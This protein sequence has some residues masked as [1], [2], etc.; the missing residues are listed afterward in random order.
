MSETTSD[1]KTEEPTPR[2]LEKAIE[3]GQIAF[4]SE[5]MGG[6]VVLAGVLFFLFLGRWFFDTI[7]NSIRE[8]LFYFQPMIDD[9]ISVL[10]A[11]RHSLTQFGMACGALMVFNFVVAAAAGAFQTKFNLSMKPISFDLSKLSP[12]KGLK[13]IFSSRSL[14]RGLVAISKATAIVLAAIYLTKAKLG[15]I[16][17]A[18]LLSLPDAIAVG[19]ELVLKMGLVSATLMVL[20]G[21][22]DYAFQKWKQYTDLKMSKQEVRDE[23]KD[24]DGD[25]L[26]KARL[27]RVQN[28]RAKNRMLQEVPTATV[29]ITNPTHFAVAVKYSA[30]ENSAPIVV[31]KGQDLLAFRIIEIAKEN[32]VAVVERKPVARFLYANV[33]VGQPIPYE[34]YQAVA[35][36]LNFIRYAESRAA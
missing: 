24:I 21:I 10:L 13:R 29:V 25:P 28:E 7:Q 8:R 11:F 32:G 22:G 35:E 31:A 4:S 6:L 34:L 20:I 14:M 5:L 26:L 36:I 19:S 2:K 16:M 17:N 1:Q 27:R 33:N 9:R 12:Q 15:L 18:G 30:A 3:D 23:S